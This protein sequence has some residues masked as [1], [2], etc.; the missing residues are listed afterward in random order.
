MLANVRRYRF[1]LATALGC[2]LLCFVAVVLG[3]MG[4][5]TN[6]AALVW[7]GELLFASA[8]ILMPVVGIVSVVWSWRMARDRPPE[9]SDA[10]DVVEFLLAGGGAVQAI[11]GVFLWPNAVWMLL[12][13][14][15][16][17]TW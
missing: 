3:V 2:P 17:S 10:N 6:I 1:H 14:L 15:S 12:W 13:C 7:L 4:V 9:V 5:L 11:L 16:V 8:M